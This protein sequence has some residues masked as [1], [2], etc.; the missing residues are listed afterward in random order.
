MY[1]LSLCDVFMLVNDCVHVCTELITHSIYNS[2]RGGAFNAPKGSDSSGYGVLSAEKVQ[3]NVT[4]IDIRWLMKAGS[5][6]LVMVRG[7]QVLVDLMK[8][9]GVLMMECILVQ[10]LPQSE[11]ILNTVCLSMPSLTAI[12]AS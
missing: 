5:H 10:Q 4:M 2:P 6:Q 11:C 12:I 8:E 1:T 9:M 3:M 7:R